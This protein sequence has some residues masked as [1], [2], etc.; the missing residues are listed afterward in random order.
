MSGYATYRD[1]ACSGPVQRPRDRH[2]GISRDE[3]KTGKYIDTFRPPLVTAGLNFQCF[4]AA[5]ASFAIHDPGPTER[6]CR[7]RVPFPIP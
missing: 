1:F 5:T 7:S 2:F 6:E 3:T 4:T